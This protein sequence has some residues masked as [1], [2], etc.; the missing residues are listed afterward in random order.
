MTTPRPA[1]HRTIL[2]V[3][4]EGFGAR[5]RTNPH[6]L[7]VRK[8]L[9][10]ALPQA[11]GNVGVTWAECHHEDCGDGV[12]V[13]IPPTV[14]KSVLVEALPEELVSA[15]EARRRPDPPMK[16]LDDG[17]GPAR[18]RIPSGREKIGRV[19]CPDTGVKRGER[20]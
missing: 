15:L 6:R 20:T 9:Y 8:G 11:L 3:D 17:C 1:V 4:V 5:R 12:L 2:A 16:R 13:A 14:A 10:R 19:E 7:A 18:S